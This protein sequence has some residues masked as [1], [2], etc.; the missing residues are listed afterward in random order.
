MTYSVQICLAQ[1]CGSATLHLPALWGAG[2]KRQTPEWGEVSDRRG[3]GDF[4][5]VESTFLKTGSDT[6]FLQFIR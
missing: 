3:Q 2:E 5:R 1:A 4:T 6:Q